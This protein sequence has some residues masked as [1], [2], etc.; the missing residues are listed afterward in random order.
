VSFGLRTW[1]S[2]GTLQLD[3]N[4]FTYQIIFS[5]TYKLTLGQVLTIPIAGFTVDKCSASILPLDA[6]TSEDSYEAL[7]YI[8]VVNGSITI[9]SIHPDDPYGNGSL[10]RFRL[11][12]MRYRN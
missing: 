12:V 4:N 11:L 7:P 8:R 9:R 6:A 10:M 5:Q 2:K 3:T 1:S